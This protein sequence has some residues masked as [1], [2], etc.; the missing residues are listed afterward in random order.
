MAE[1]VCK[2]KG[3]GNHA[4]TI[5]KPYEVLI[6]EDGYVFIKND[7]NKTARY[8]KKLFKEPEPEVVVPAR[9]EQDCIDSI[10]CDQN[11]VN[12]IDLDGA[13]V[14]ITIPFKTS[15]TDISCGIKQVYNINDMIENI[16]EAV[17]VEDDDR[18]DLKK[19]LFKKATLTYVEE[20]GGSAM[21]ILS[22]NTS[23]SDDEGVAVDEDMLKV[24][25]QIAHTTSE[26]VENP[27]SGNKIKMWVFYTHKL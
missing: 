6:D 22:T 13:A 27:E 25:D 16:N 11:T 8:S 20:E 5:T 10:E 23:G 2:S 12:F 24:L 17:N 18:L 4:L 14:S 26:E 1:L 7:N 15:T 3:N 19:A 21:S 9:T